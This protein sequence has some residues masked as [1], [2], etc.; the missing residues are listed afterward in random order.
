MTIHQSSTTP[1]HA[2]S[3]S[4]TW[5][6]P[7]PPPP[8]PHAP[9]PQQLQP[10]L[11][12]PPAPGPSFQQPYYYMPE[13]LGL[14]PARQPR[15]YHTVRRVP[16][17]K[18]NLVLD[19]PVPVQ[20]LQSTPRRAGSEF[21]QMRYTAVTSDP[22][23]FESYTLR[24]TSLYRATE[25][26][27]CITMY[28]EDE[29]LLAR[30][31]HG[32]M[33]NISHLCSRK[34]SR[35]WASRHGKNN[36]SW[37]K[38]VVCIIADGREKIHPRVL[39]LLSA[40]GVYQD[41]V[42][43]NFVN[44]KQVQAHLYEFT[45]QLSLNPDLKFKNAMDSI[46]PTQILFCLKEKNQRKINSHRWFFQAFCAQLKPSVCMLLDVGT[47]PGPS[48]I[49]RLWKTFD[50]NRD[51]GGAC[52]EVRAMTGTAGIALL[53][54]LVAAQNFEYKISNVLDKPL[55]SVLGYIQVLP[56]AFSAYRY[57]ALLNDVNG[58]GPLEKYFLGEELHDG[59][60]AAGVFEANMYL[61]EDRILCFELVAKKDAKWV[62][63]Y[64][65]NA[66]G[67]TDVPNG[68]PEFISQRRRWLNGSFFAGIYALFHWGKIITT[69]HSLLR[70]M[71]LII[72]VVYLFLSW[73]FSWFALAN[74]FLSFYILTRALSTMT[75]PPYDRE[76]AHN[77][78]VGLTYVYVVLLIVLFLFAMGNRPQGSKGAYTL[79]MVFFAL[80]MIYMIFAS[81]WLAYDAIDH[82]VSTSTLLTDG[83]FR[84]ILIAVG[85]TYAIYLAASLLFLDPW[86]MMTSCVQY[87]LMTPSYINILNT[88]A[89]CNT[90][91]ISW[92][93]KDITLVATDLGIV[94][95]TQH[96][97]A[98]VAVPEQKDVG[99][100]YEEACINLQERKRDEK[101]EPDPKTKQEDYYR[102]FRTRL[103]TSWILSNLI[104]VALITTAQT[105]EWL[106]DFDQRTNGYMAFV[107][108][109]VAALAVFRFIGSV[110][111]RILS[112][113]TGS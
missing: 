24:Q 64:V 18:G 6:P 61:A 97:Q 12:P 51:V 73:L 28:N 39:D 54:P 22:A 25:L 81:V 60:A 15:R 68:V 30:T 47:R 88:F 10:Q 21:E 27:I 31:L 11:I 87:V 93:T 23:N 57:K 26:F 52:G 20:Y 91:D 112:I 106:G 77:V 5:I 86:H 67:E 58:H 33:K 100:L 108:W 102:A 80:L 34:R 32:V 62:L 42:A 29:V 89:F 9:P 110:T 76:T 50:I 83:S 69:K 72:Q 94:E 38:V 75:N 79:I 101:H 92:G 96:G 55:E 84:D 107:L 16:L 46:V 17:T 43:K 74:F 63:H 85:A 59:A 14:A 111:Y 49:Y 90:H 56:G 53:N 82:A 66:Y 103:V 37:K 35:T 3:S 1:S 99:L 104:L 95:S 4:H 70:K 65:S 7:P 71:L 105:L 45:T 44:R 113:F 2:T 19:C 98:D 36:E 109:A 78:H 40:L 8:P 13:W 41:G 48:S